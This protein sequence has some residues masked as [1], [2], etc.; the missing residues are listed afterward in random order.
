MDKMFD[1]IIVDGDFSSLSRL[2]NREMPSARVIRAESLI[3]GSNP[4]MLVCDELTN[5]DFSQLEDRAHA[6][7]LGEQIHTTFER[8]ATGRLSKDSPEFQELPGTR[9]LKEKAWDALLNATWGHSP[10]KRAAIKDQLFFER[11]I[12]RSFSNLCAP[13]V[14]ADDPSRKREPKGPRGKWGKLK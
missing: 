12:T 14:G 3:R 8:V 13:Q 1:V 10:E 11:Y 5:V 6:M 7:M 2:I 4:K 9:E